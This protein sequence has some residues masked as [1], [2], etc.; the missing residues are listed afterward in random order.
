MG[1]GRGFEPPTPWSPA[2]SAA[3]TRKKL[4]PV[5]PNAERVMPTSTPTF[6][7][8]KEPLVGRKLFSHGEDAK[9]QMQPPLGLLR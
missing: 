2:P 3:R 5:Q 1:G 4:W 8:S 9:Y 7:D 6:A